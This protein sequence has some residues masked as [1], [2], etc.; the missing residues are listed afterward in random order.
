M[1]IKLFYHK[2]Y[3][4][5]LNINTYNQNYLILEILEQLYKKC[6]WTDIRLN[7]LGFS[8]IVI[9]INNKKCY[10]KVSELQTWFEYKRSSDT[11]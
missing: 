4:K 9:N 1:K 11:I 10:F 3:D 7:S 6:K 5:M 8:G 2:M